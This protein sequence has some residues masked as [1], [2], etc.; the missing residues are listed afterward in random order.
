MAGHTVLAAPN[1]PIVVAVAER[2]LETNE[3]K[4]HQRRS[5]NMRHIA[6]FRECAG[7]APRRAPARCA[8]AS[9]Y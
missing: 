9:H 4:R 5:L 8:L 2:L 1:D 7:T 3:C 6:L